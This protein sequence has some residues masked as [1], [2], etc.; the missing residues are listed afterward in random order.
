ML[1]L[2]KDHWKRNLESSSSR[3]LKERALFIIPFPWQPINIGR[4]R[5]PNRFYQLS[6]VNLCEKDFETLKKIS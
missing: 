6:Q 2:D 4:L 1:E 3:N 5:H